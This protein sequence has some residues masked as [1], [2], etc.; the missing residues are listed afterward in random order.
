MTIAGNEIDVS[1]LSAGDEQDY[2]NS[3]EQA[4][5]SYGYFGSSVIVTSFSLPL[6]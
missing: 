4:I 1:E 6:S 2:Q 3:L 5:N